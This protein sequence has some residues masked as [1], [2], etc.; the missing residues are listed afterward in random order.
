MA[1]GHKALEA[2]FLGS[3]FLLYHLL[4]GEFGPVT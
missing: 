4:A 1:T 3:D 2:H